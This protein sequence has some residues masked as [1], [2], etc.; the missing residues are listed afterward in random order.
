MNTMCLQIYI[1][2]KIQ[3]Y[4]SSPNKYHNLN[5]IIRKQNTQ[6]EEHFIRGGK[7][8]D[9]S[10]LCKNNVMALAS[11]AQLVKSVIP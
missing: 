7:R 8:E 2:K 11:V 9:G 4:C 10:V 3:H 6:N 5:L 1:L